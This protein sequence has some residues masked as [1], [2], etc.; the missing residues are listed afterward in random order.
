MA[1]D[2]RRTVP[3]SR[4]VKASIVDSYEDIGKTQE[5]YSHWAARGL[6]KLQ[7]ETLSLGVRKVLLH[8]S[9]GLHTAT[10]PLD[11][12]GDIFVG[13]IDDKGNKEPLLMMPDLVDI[14][15]IKAYA[16]E[17]KCPR[18]NQDKAICGDLT[19]TIEV[20]I[21]RINGANYDQTITKKLYPNG[22]YYLETS[23]PFQPLD[24]G[25]FSNNTVQYTI[26]K[27]FIGKIDL[28]DCGCIDETVSNL[29][30]IKSFNSDVYC[31][32]F[33]N[34]C[35]PCSSRWGGYRVFEETG[36]IQLDPRYPFDVVYLEYKSFLPKKDGQYQA[37]EVAFETLVEWIKWKSIANRKNVARWERSDQWEHYRIERANMQKVMGKITVGQLMQSVGLTPKFN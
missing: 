30:N 24:R 7:H 4:I 9:K 19:T 29:E 33:I 23:T 27:E 14:E 5:L 10:L 17:D 36:T 15:N 26:T 3:L 32:Y 35:I 11:F 20:K 12:N 6:R 31:N 22:D 16:C 25:G 1:V 34:R 18:C 28:K 13:V 21:V 8:V 2:L 37:P